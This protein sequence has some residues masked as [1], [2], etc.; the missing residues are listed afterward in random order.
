MAG[1]IAL[2]A[3]ALMVVVCAICWLAGRRSAS[4]IGSGLTWAGVA[5]IAVGVLST[6][7]GW[8]V[9]R[10]PQIMYA[11]SVSHQDMPSRTRQAVRDSL[12]C[13]NLAIIATAVGILCIIVGALL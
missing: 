6:L 13:Y 9:T 1:L 3:L 4:Q 8:G 7:G 11:Q 12:R 2:A 5:A 10:D